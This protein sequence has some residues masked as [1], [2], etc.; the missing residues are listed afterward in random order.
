[1]VHDEEFRYKAGLLDSKDRPMQEDDD[2]APGF[3]V[4]YEHDPIAEAA[5]ADKAA[6]V[7]L[8][9]EELDGES[10]SSSVNRQG[11]KTE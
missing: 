3:G 9:V 10:V 7:A 6:R 2:D 4:E 1:M 5:A 11:H 8:V